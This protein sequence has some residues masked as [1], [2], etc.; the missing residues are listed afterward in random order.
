MKEFCFER[1]NGEINGKKRSGEKDD[2]ALKRENFE[3]QKENQVNDTQL[4]RMMA[5]MTN[6]NSHHQ[7]MDM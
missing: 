3:I 5:T 7:I 4:M 6:R 2:R 1:K